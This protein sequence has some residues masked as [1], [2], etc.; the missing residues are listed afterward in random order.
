ISSNLSIWSVIEPCISIIAACLPTL[1]PLIRDGVSLLS[2]ARRLQQRFLKR[3]RANYIESDR[4][5][6]PVHRTLSSSGRAWH[7]F[8]EDC[9]NT[10]YSVEVELG[11]PARPQEA[12]FL[13]AIRLG[14]GMDD[15]DSEEPSS[16]RVDRSFG[17]ESEQ[18]RI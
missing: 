13:K 12:C 15:D 14:D 16:I 8:Q 18:R 10:S 9:S 5:T 1:G 3:S 2:L 4:G 11:K 6:G 7:K 17:T